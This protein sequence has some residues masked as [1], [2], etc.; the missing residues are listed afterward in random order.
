MPDMAPKS[1]AAGCS[2]IL[3]G[4]L[5]PSLIG[6]LSYQCLKIELASS[7]AS[8]TQTIRRLSSTTVP[9]SLNR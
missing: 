5:D 6:R 4:A 2:T 8:G 3:Y 9:Y 1:L 7:D